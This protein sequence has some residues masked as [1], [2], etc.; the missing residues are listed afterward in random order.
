MDELDFLMNTNFKS[1]FH[2]SQ[3][4]HPLLKEAATKR[5][6]L[7]ESLARGESAQ[8]AVW[9]DDEQAKPA[10][11]APASLFAAE[12]SAAADQERSYSSIINIGSASSTIPDRTGSIYAATKAAMDMLTKNLACEWA[13]D[14][15]RVNC[16]SPWYIATDLALQV[17]KNETFKDEVLGRTP[18]RR[19][20]DVQEVASTVAYLA[21]PA[22]NYITGQILSVDGGY[23]INGLH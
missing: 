23:T 12:A 20:G 3:L 18:M 9:T 13:H 2:L 11:D 5:Q 17:L 1:C 6:Q 4:C 16:V 8:N 19:V 21:M 7:R 14:G 15:I 10:Q 22:A